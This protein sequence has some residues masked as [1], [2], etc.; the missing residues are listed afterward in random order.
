MGSDRVKELEKKLEDQKLLY[1]ERGKLYT[2]LL[3]HSSD[4]IFSF[5]PD[6]TYLYI[7]NAFANPMKRTPSDIIGKKI[8]D[9]FSKEEADKRFA[10][11]KKVFA[12]KTTENIEVRVDTPTGDVIYFLTTVKPILNEEGNP[13]S[14]ICISKNI[15]EFKKTKMALEVAKEEAEQANKA[16]SEFISNMSHELRTPL[17][18]VIGFSELLSNMSEN[19]EELNYINS[20]R[21]AGKNLLTLINDILDLSK[22]EAGMLIVEPEEVNINILLEEI[23]QIFKTKIEDKGV[24]FDLLV[25]SDIPKVIK[26]D[27]TRLR[28][29]LFN[30]VGN[31]DKFTAKG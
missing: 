13:T 28:Q 30:L 21:V 14:V 15:T 8:W 4:P 11:V 10:L 7:N 6:G 25:S 2:D 26:I 27:E 17:N 23:S 1:E 29:I 9:V 22:I 31:A 19:S 5:A 12:T 18:A 16:K 24:S 20:I 3:D